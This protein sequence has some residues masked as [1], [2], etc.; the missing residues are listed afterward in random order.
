MADTESATEGV[1]AVAETA[2][3]SVAEPTTVLEN[4]TNIENI[5][6]LQSYL[7]TTSQPLCSSLLMV[8]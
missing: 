5:R 1:E 6:V 8:L 4:V 3:E 2:T 7:A